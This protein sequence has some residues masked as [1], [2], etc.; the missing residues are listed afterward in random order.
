MGW[1]FYDTATLPEI[2]DIVWCK[3]PQ[4]EDR[5]L[6]GPV[7]RPV[8]VR[9]IMILEDGLAGVQYGAVVISYGSGAGIDD[10]A[11]KNDFV[12]EDWAEVH[13]AGLH[14]PTRFSLD[15]RDRKRLPWC[16][17]YFVPPDYKVNGKL[18]LGR[19][20]ESQQSR[21]RKLLAAR[22]FQGS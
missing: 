11:R 12:V 3:W 15:P 4:R 6:P 14:K 1:K 18:I 21:L 16:E 10:V 8:L 2:Y 9:E 20:T 13:A 19:L 22:G 7:I 17:E 5:N